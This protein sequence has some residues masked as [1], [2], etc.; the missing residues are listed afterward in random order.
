MIKKINTKL[1]E[2]GYTVLRFWHSEL[3]TN[4]EKC[5]KEILKFAKL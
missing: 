4:P 5:I 3:E 1:E 2:L